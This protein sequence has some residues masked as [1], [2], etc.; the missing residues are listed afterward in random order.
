[1]AKAKRSGASHKSYYTNYKT[2]KRWS[3]NRLK[4]LERALKRNPEN[5]E[6]IKKAMANVEYRRKTPIVPKW[7]ATTR[8]IA[9]LFKL[10]QGKVPAAAIAGVTP[11]SRD[12]EEKYWR[13]LNEVKN[14]FL[15][16]AD[17]FSG[18]MFSIAAR[19]SS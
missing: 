8:R 13:Q 6:Q 16:K 11:K 15:Q 10:F 17:K 19:I 7:S 4:K 12:E 3:T 2:S 5:A 9:E 14:G 18:S 1:M